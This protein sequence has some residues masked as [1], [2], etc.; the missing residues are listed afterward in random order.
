MHPSFDENCDHQVNRGKFNLKTET[1]DTLR[2]LLKDTQNHGQVEN[3]IGN[4]S[5]I[6]TDVNKKNNYNG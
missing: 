2:N 1:P 3:I 4:S 6:E 5:Q